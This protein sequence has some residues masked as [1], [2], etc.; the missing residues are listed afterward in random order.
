MRL[1]REEEERRKEFRKQLLQ[2]IQDGHTYLDTGGQGLEKL[3][4]EL[5]KCEGY[6]EAEVFSEEFDGVA[7]ADVRAV[8]ADRFGEQKLLVQVKHHWGSSGNHGIDQLIAIPEQAP[9]R[10]EDHKLVLVTTGSVEDETQ[11]RADEHDIDIL[12]SDDFA[13]WLLDHIEHVDTEMRHRLGISD[14]P[15]LTM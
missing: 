3:V 1:E 13:D 14:L 8:R 12:E 7:D 15:Q 11:N 2:N 4:A 5:L 6:D 10:Y 9:E